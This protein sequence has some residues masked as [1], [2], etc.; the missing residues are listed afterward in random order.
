MGSTF[1]RNRIGMVKWDD[2]HERAQK[3]LDSMGSN[4]NPRQLVSTLSVAQQQ[5]V[6][7]ARALSF[8]AEV[9]I[10]DE[11]TASLTDKE[12]TKLFQIIDDLKR[13]LKT[14][15][16]KSERYE[17]ALCALLKLSQEKDQD[18]LV[19]IITNTLKGHELK[20]QFIKD[21]LI[22]AVIILKDNS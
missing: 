18:M 17:K 2:V 12:I 19:D 1:P 15:T 8:K 3:V 21:A 16:E 6:E 4:L 7:I 20:D 22:G 14:Q 5:M 10:M 11:P 9:L 13:T